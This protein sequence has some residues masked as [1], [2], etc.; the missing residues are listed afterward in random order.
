MIG[1]IKLTQSLYVFLF[2]FLL[3]GDKIFTQSKMTPDNGW[4]NKNEV[5]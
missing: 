5:Q 3:V 2:I 1:H 4:A